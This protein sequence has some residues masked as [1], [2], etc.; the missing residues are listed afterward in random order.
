MNP[1][2]IL[3]GR[4]T[5]SP[6]GKLQ[7]FPAAGWREEF[8]A[9]REI[10]FDAMELLVTESDWESNPLRT[11]AGTDVLRGL[12]ESHAIRLTSILHDGFKEHPPFLES[13]RGREEAGRRLARILAAARRLGIRRVVLPLLEGSSVREERVRKAFAES[14]PVLARQAEAAGVLLALES[15]LPAA[16]LASLLARTGSGC[17]KVNYDVGNAAAEGGDVAAE[18]RRLGSAIAGVHVKDRLPAGPSVPLGEGA[19]DFPAAFEALKAVGYTGP[20][21]LETPPGADPIRSAGAN[22]RLVR[23]AWH[24]EY[25]R[26]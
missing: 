24:A 17:W 20:L 10:G 22:L 1:V 18:I 19:A 12:A 9:A 6:Q 2:G 3:Q 13:G 15:D 14:A 7:V 16:E 8:R 23:E 4:L 26:R 5:R 25:T 21:V 11:E